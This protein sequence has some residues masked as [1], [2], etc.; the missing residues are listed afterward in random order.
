[1]NG[2]TQIQNSFTQCHN[3]TEGAGGCPAKIALSLPLG[4]GRLFTIQ[5]STQKMNANVLW[6]PPPLPLIPS[7]SNFL[8]EYDLIVDS[9]AANIWARERDIK[10]VSNKMIFNFSLQLLKLTSGYELDISDQTGGWANTGWTIPELE[11]SS[12]HHFAHIGTWDEVTGVYSYVG[13]TIDG[14]PYSIPAKLQTLK[15]IPLAW[16]DGFYPQ[17]QQD[18]DGAINQDLGFSEFITDMNL[19][20]W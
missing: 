12:M 19:V 1:M 7:T 6:Y 11:I 2:Y 13:V 10:I 15:A 20:A 5:G 8:F 16:P 18:L 3:G 4:N 14:T 17:F 9:N